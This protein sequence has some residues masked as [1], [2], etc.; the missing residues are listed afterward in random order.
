MTDELASQRKSLAE[1]L[2][3]R[4]QA[5]DAPLTELKDLQERLRIVDNVLAEQ[6]AAAGRSLGRVLAPMLAVAVVLTLAATL[7]VPAVPLG[8]E[9][10]AGSATL[11]M[12]GASA[13]GPL[14]LRGDTRVEGFSLLASPDSSLVQAFVA[15]PSGAIVLRADEATLSTLRWPAD[16]RLTMQADPAMLSLR[17]EGPGSGAQAEFDVRGRS[18][19]RLS[20]AALPEERRYDHGEWIRLAAGDANGGGASSMTLSLS[21]AVDAPIRLSELRPVALRF[22]E[23]R[24]SASGVAAVVSSIEGGTITLPATGE[25]VK[26]AAG[27]WLELD[28]L[29]IERCEVVADGLLTLRLNG[30]AGAMRLRVGEFERS[31]KPSWLEYTARHH[32]MKLLWGAA[33]VLWGALA[34]MRNQF[35]DVH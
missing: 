1:Q 20:E 6:R 9:L 12:A 7:Q 3:A 18:T 22:A 4:L 17:L 11:T 35:A 15:N 28:G 25:S 14:G 8:L 26:L 32:L 23:R 16:S 10:Q 2:A 27:D 31:L 34:W 33:A 24:A 13:I 30:S 21:R 19:L 29:V 5:P